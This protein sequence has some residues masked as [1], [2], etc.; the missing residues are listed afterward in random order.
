MCYSPRAGPE[1]LPYSLKRNSIPVRPFR[2]G[3]TVRIGGNNAKL[4]GLRRRGSAKEKHALVPHSKGAA[5]IYGEF[6]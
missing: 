6:W 3:S 5:I 2:F 4:R 1:N